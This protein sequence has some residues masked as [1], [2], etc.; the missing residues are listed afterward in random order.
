MKIWFCN[1]LLFS[2]SVEMLQKHFPL[3][4]KIFK[5]ALEKLINDEIL[6]REG[7]GEVKY[8]G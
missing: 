8:I 6:S 4:E 1:R 7:K 2:A 5:K 3:N